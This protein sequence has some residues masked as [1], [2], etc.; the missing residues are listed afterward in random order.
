VSKPTA[1]ILL[2]MRQGGCQE[3]RL[4]PTIEKCPAMSAAERRAGIAQCYLSKLTG[5]LIEEEQQL[6][7]AVM[8]GGNSYK[9]AIDTGATASFVSEEMA[10][11]TSALGRITRT[12]RQV[13]LADGRC[14]GI[15]AQLE[16]EVKFGNKQVTMSLLI[17]PGV[18]DLLVE[19]PETSRNRDK[20]FLTRDN[21]TNQVPTQWMARGKAF[22]TII[23]RSWKQIWQTSAQ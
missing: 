19:P 20:V 18:V 22:W 12:R 6:H 17:L 7:A 8:I 21:N 1:V 9:A 14:G 11:N 15:N 2:D 23:Q 10:D 3:R 5:K 13:R 16:V 4:L